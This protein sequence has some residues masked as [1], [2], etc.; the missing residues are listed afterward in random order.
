M[1]LVVFRAWR[2]V[3][4]VVQ[5]A[6][7]ARRSH[8]GLRDSAVDDPSP[9]EAERRIDLTAFRAVV[10]VAELVMPDQFAMQSGVE[11]GVEGRPVPPGEEPQKKISQAHR[12]RRPDARAD[13]ASATGRPYGDAAR[14][15][16][17]VVLHA[18]PAPEVVRE[19]GLARAARLGAALSTAAR[20]NDSLYIFCPQYLVYAPGQHS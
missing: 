4:G 2:N 9:L 15:C 5:P 16:P 8:R 7:P 17:A 18:A 13:A 19:T 1:R 3:D 6:V 11:Q 20:N 10:G 12:N 14:A